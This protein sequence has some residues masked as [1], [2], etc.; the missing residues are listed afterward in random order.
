MQLLRCY[1]G[2]DLQQAFERVDVDEDGVINVDELEQIAYSLNL[3]LSHPQAEAVMS[4]FGTK[5][6]HH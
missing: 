4:R 5:G 6:Q 1:V 3:K 2:A